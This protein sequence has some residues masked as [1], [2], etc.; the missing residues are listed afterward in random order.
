MVPLEKI[1]AT[2][3]PEYAGV[4]FALS[5]DG[6]VQLF[7]ANATMVVDLPGPETIWDY[8][9]AAAG[10]VPNAS[11]RMLHGRGTQTH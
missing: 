5:P 4:D 3:Q 11:R 8:R 9:R 1:S 10:A 2:L 6:R 7:E